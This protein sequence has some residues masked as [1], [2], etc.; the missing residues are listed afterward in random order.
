M[1]DILLCPDRSVFPFIQDF[2][3]DAV[4]LIPVIQAR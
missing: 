3:H 2:V 1:A 4:L